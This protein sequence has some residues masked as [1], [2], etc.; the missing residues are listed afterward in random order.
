ML[1]EIQVV[2]DTSKMKEYKGR[3]SDFVAED[4]SQIVSEL[5]RDEFNMKYVTVN[6][7]AI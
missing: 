7:E 5:L 4:L 3:D 6:A 2:I 1:V